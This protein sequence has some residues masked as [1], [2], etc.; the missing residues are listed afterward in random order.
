MSTSAVS[1]SSNS[2]APHSSAPH[3]T[4]PVII[5]LA[6]AAFASASAFRICDPLLPV[7][8]NDFGVR[9]AQASNS[10]TFFAIAYGVMQFFYG[11]ML[12]YPHSQLAFFQYL[13]RF[14]YG[15]VA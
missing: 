12:Q 13:R 8:A 3:S 6:L 4:T 14:L 10:V 1:G 5:L 15:Q 2:P 11:P 9:T 7:L